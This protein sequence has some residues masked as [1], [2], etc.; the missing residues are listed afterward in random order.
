MNLIGEKKTTVVQLRL[1]ARS[2]IAG[3]G[4]RGIII[5]SPSP[6]TR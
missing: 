1:P 5:V 4:R 3:S 6:G 2:R